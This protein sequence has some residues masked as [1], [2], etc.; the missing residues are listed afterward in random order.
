[1]K[2]VITQMIISSKIKNKK[3]YVNKLKIII[4]IVTIFK[5]C[6]KKIKKN[7]KI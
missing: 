2:L 7:K 6:R 5:K 3:I 1:M 4:T